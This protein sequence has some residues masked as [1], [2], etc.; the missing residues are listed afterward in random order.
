MYKHLLLASLK[1]YINLITDTLMKSLSFNCNFN[2]PLLY[3]TAH[4]T[5]T[6]ITHTQQHPTDP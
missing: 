3:Y 2:L 5:H 6:L 4:N 1:K